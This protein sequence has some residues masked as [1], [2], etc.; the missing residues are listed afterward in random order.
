MKIKIIDKINVKLILFIII[1]TILSTLPIFL[2]DELPYGGDLN[3]HLKRIEAIA[4][5]IK[6]SLFGYPIYYNYLGGYGYASKLFYPDL[7]LYIPAFFNLSGISLFTSYKIF[8]FIIKLTSIITMYIS[9][10]GL[11]KNKY[12]IYCSITLYALS[13]YCFVD[14]FERGALAETMTIIF[15][16]LIIRGIYEIIYGN[17]KKYYYLPIGLLG[18]LYSH[19]ISTYIITIFIII[20]LL[21]NIKNLN[22]EKIKVL[23]KTV[24]IVLL[25]GSNYIF[26][27]LEQM[28]SGDF[29]YN[30][31]DTN[32]ISNNTI[33][34]YLSFLELPYYTLMG[35]DINRWIPP[36]IGII[37]LY[38]C[39]YSL[40]NIKKLTKI[41]KIFIITS[42]ITLLFSTKIP[43]WNIGIISKLFSVIQFPFRIYIL[44][45]TLF[46]F[47][48]VFVFNTLNKKQFKLLLTLSIIMFSLNIFY[49]FI[50]IKTK[51]LQ[52]DEIMYGEY[53]PIEYP[54]LDYH[55][56]RKDKIISDCNINYDIKRDYI[57][58]ISYESECNE[59]N[60]EI[61]IIYY[62]GYVA[63]NDN[64]KIAVK[65]SENGLIEINT[66]EKEGI[67]EIIYEGTKIYNITKIISIISIIIFIKVVY[68]EKKT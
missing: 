16:P 28:N 36:G 57:T 19:L 25:I 54:E 67:I 56:D 26:P 1:L 61:P 49:P 65:K 10:R 64:K 20:F 35:N 27:L 45:T 41:S 12:L 15:V 6:N 23:I 63:K 33:P 17:H 31:I 55:K 24:L 8:L 51:S 18:I 30:N 40:K 7:F 62:K 22:K 66:T 32:I 38:L 11:T 53:L 4:L 50:N 52:E 9:I 48:F 13:S 21:I 47:S 59:N 58:T 34:I 44:S 37:Y 60:L 43:I 39:I 29:Y 2:M 68:Y 3:F 14:M 5:N 42:I 46:I